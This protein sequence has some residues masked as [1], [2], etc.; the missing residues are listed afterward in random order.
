MKAKLWVP[1]IAIAAVIAYFA[2]RH[3]STTKPAAQ[4]AKPHVELKAAAPVQAMPAAH[5]DD[6]T[7]TVRLEGQVIDEQDQPVAGASVG[8]DANPPKLVTSDASGNFVIEGLLARDYTIEASSDRGYAGAR[9]RLTATPEPVTLRIRAG[10]SVE[11]SVTDGTAP[12]ANADVELRSTVIWHGRT[13]ANGLVTFTNVGAVWGPVVASAAGFAPSAT[14]LGTTGH[15]L[16]RVA[17]RLVKGAAVTGTVVD[18]AGKPVEGARVVATN[19][20]EPFPVVDPRRDGVVTAANGAF[21][22]PAI[23]PG[24]WR[25]TATKAGY[26]ST[27]NAPMILD[28]VSARE[29]TLIL[30]RGITLTGKVTSAGKAIASANVSVLSP[31]NVPWR[32]RRQTFTA[33]DG[34]FTVSGLPKTTVDVV[35][36]ATT[37]SPIAHVDLAT[38]TTVELELSITGA[39]TGSVVDSQGQPVGDAQVFAEPAPTGKP[40]DITAWIVRGSQEVVTDQAG[41]FTLAGLPDGAYQVRA[42]RPSAG[43]DEQGLAQPVAAKPGDSIK[44]TLSTDGTLHGKIAFSDG[45]A[46]NAFV[47]RL[48]SSYAKSFLGTAEFKITAPQGTHSFVVDGPSFLAPAARDITVG[49]DLDLGTITVQK[50]RSVSGHVFDQ[51]N[52]PVADARV[53]AGSLLTGGGSELYIPDESIGAKDT[54]TDANGYFRID[55]FSP[56]PLAIVAGTTTARSPSAS[57]PANGDSVS[58]DLVLAPMSGLDGK[59]TRNNAPLGDTPVLANPIGGRGQTFFTVT[60]ADGSFAFD[61]LA[62]GTYAVSPM[63]GGGGPK[64]KDIYVVK[65]EVVLGSRGHL[66]IDATP[67]P[68]SLTVTVPGIATG[69]LMAIGAKITAHTLEDLRMLDQLTVLS[70]VPTPVHM[71]G[72]MNGAIEIDGMRPGDYTVCAAGFTGRPPDDAKTVPVSCEQVAVTAPKQTLTISRSGP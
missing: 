67:G 55:G 26:A 52:K 58:I 54:T 66:T 44:I 65:A 40:D 16:A 5:D 14:M 27:T 34:T 30:A 71:R 35:A 70:D 4:T 53:A 13:N 28:G 25:L 36:Q 49:K 46:P 15:D 63:I 45:T 10:G 48:G 72:I 43:D 24:S 39:I 9:V 64:P 22:L 51:N 8:I 37:A 32:A 7:G 1:V 47:I 20:S 2:Y 50:G 41:A 68:D 56:G 69:Q 33:A 18:E 61:A 11:V 62:P 57:L 31:G 17:L 23:S 3:H 60:G 29:A 42:T 6:P 21:T 59:V 12:I 38:K 19:A